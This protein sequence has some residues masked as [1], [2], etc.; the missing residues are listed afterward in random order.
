MFRI[1]L[2]VFDLN[3]S[4]GRRW[5][6]AH[7]REGGLYR[8]VSKLCLLGGDYGWC[9]CHLE[10]RR[11]RLA[12]LSLCCM[13]E[14]RRNVALLTA[15]LGS[16]LD[17]VFRRRLISL[18]IESRISIAMRPGEGGCCLNSPRRVALDNAVDERKP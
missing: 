13:V 12:F 18:H 10:R 1:G 14:G 6:S 8:P 2:S 9:I 3:T 17:R 16:V 11:C 15:T 4:T 5:G 7:D